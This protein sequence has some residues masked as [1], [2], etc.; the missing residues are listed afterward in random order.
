LGTNAANFF[1]TLGEKNSDTNE[2]LGEKNLNSSEAVD[3]KN[4]NS[5]DAV[6][7]KNSNSSEA[8]DEKNSNSSEAVGEKNLNSSEA[9]DEKISNSSETIT[10]KNSN[11]TE[12]AAE[13][14]ENI[15]APVV[16]KAANF[17]M[18][19]F[20]GNIFTLH[21][22]IQNEKPI[23]INF[24]A[25][26]CPP[27]RVEMPDFEKIF[28]EQ[29]ENVQFIML[30][31]TDGS[32]ETKENGK[33]FIDENGYTFPVFFDSNKNA[34]S[35]YAIRSIPTTVFVNANGSVSNTIIGILSEEK[36]RNEISLLQ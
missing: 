11:S 26:W 12:T 17:S 25:S 36:L 1:E 10:E 2:A 18:T 30:N 5:S 31:L 23:V 22:I 8:L 14:P 19:D 15:P 33:K 35:A 13:K 4:S 6:D 21:E 3:E 9:V 20:E 7:E 28:R 16:N 24:W 27:C 32:R 34:A 29:G